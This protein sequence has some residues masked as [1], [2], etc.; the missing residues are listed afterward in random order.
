MKVGVVTPPDIGINFRRARE[1]GLKV[2][3]S[4]F[5]SAN[6]IYNN[7]DIKVRPNDV[8]SK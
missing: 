1:I 3:F 8:S 6:V 2:P 4:F 7:D 5:E